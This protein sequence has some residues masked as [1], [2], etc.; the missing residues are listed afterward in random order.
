MSISGFKSVRIDI[1]RPGLRG[2]CMFVRND[3]GFSVVDLHGI[4]HPSV[5]IL[6]VSISC[7]LDSP[8]VIFNMY[9]HPLIF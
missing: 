8:V 7:S 6:G 9:R 3:Y 5:E 4:S 1:I 2:L